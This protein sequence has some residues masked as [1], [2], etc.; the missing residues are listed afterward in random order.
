MFDRKP[1]MWGRWNGIAHLGYYAF[2]L[3]RLKVS[4]RGS[5]L[6][7]CS[8]VRV[9]ACFKMR[10]NSSDVP[11]ST[12]N[13]NYGSIDGIKCVHTEKNVQGA[14]PMNGTSRG[15]LKLWGLITEWGRIL[16][17]LSTSATFY[18]PIRLWH[19]LS[20]HLQALTLFVPI[21]SADN[22]KAVSLIVPALHPSLW[23][24]VLCVVVWTG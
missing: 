20:Q 5:S 8:A 19:Q 23:I 3:I 14:G 18:L 16:S 24:G 17:E 10:L 11:W 13:G 4:R 22:L 21:V 2:N 7:L 1:A 6:W 9:V 15:A 12:R